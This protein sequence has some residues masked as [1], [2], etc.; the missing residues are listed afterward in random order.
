M[1][2]KIGLTYVNL[3]LNAALKY[4]YTNTNI[5]LPFGSTFSL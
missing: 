4:K 5:H 3:R 1:V 2:E